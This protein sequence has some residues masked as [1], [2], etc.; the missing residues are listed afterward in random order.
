MASNISSANETSD[1]VYITSGPLFD[2][3]NI[4]AK[5]IKIWSF[6]LTIIYS[7]CG[8]IGNSLIIYIYGFKWKKNKT[9]VFILCLGV[10]D[11]VNCTFNMPIEI[12]IAWSPLDFD[13]HLLCKLSRGCTYVINNTGSLVFVAVAIDRYLLVYRPLKSR[14]LTP[15]FAK[16]MCLLALIIAV[17]VSWPA[18]VFYGTRTI[19]IPYGKYVVLGKTCLIS[20]NFDLTM[21]LILIFT[22]FL[23][24][25][26]I[27][28]FFILTILYIL[29][30]RKIYIATCTDLKT[31]D[32]ARESGVFGKSIL[33]AITGNTKMQHS[34]ID[35]TKLNPPRPESSVSFE[36]SLTED[37]ELCRTAIQ[38]EIANEKQKSKAN[39]RISRR[40]SSTN[41]GATRRNTIMMRVVTIAFM[42][43]FTPFLVILII[44]YTDPLFYNNIQTKAG[45][46]FYDIFLRSYLINSVVNSWIYGFMNQQFRQMVKS[47]FRRFFCSECCKNWELTGELTYALWI[48]LNIKHASNM[49]PIPLL[50]LRP[51]TKYCLFD[52]YLPTQF[53]APT[54]TFLFQFSDFEPS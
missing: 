19:T 53:F 25:L 32:T 11:F 45:K 34:K 44:R 5:S 2:A 41:S 10:L 27:I 46:I 43:S 15:K 20:D 48:P 31:S 30:G 49:V 13:W 22:T 28:I 23:F 37:T 29:I 35:E 39:S 24:T 36:I 26:L 38:K 40:Y 47:V 6:V 21:P 14:S 16:G 8:T 42:L 33:S 17:S 54:Q 51:K 3:I 7:V 1:L 18:F 4:E 9:R 50:D 12:A 52:L